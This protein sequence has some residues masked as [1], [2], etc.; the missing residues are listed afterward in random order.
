M[1]PHKEIRET[2]AVL[3]ARGVTLSQWAQAAG[4]ARS[5][6]YRLCNGEVQPT[7]AIFF[8][9]QRAANRALSAIPK[10]KSKKG[11]ARVGQGVAG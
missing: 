9:L 4:V 6:V 10:K 2:K 11:V 3:S 7:F 5:T 8:R 1:N